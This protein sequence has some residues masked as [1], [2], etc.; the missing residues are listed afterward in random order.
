MSLALI[1]PKEQQVDVKFEF[2]SKIYKSPPKNLK[3]KKKKQ[4]QQQHKPA[5][6]LPAWRAQF[7]T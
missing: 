3:K 7:T 1:I 2:I 4:Q 6:C 5:A